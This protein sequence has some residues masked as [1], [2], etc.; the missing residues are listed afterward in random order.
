[1]NAI[2]GYN[3]LLAK[4][5]LS[6]KQKDFVEHGR[7]SATHLLGIINDILDFSKA[8]AGKLHV[9]NIEFDLNDLV[10]NLSTDISLKADEKGLELVIGVMEDV[11]RYLMGDPLRISEILSGL[12]NNAVKF[13]DV[14]HIVFDCSVQKLNNHNVTLKFS[15]TDTGCGLTEEDQNSLFGSFT[16]ADTSMT[17]KYDGL[18]LGLSNCKQLVKLMGGEIGCSGEPGSGSTFWFTCTFEYK[19]EL[20]M[21]VD[22]SEDIDHD[23]EFPILNE[24][25]IL[26]VE[27]NKINQL[28]MKDI[29]EDSGVSVTIA[30]NG[31][32][33][34]TLFQSCNF[35]AILMDVQMPVL[36]GYDATRQIR[37]IESK[38]HSDFTGVNTGENGGNRNT[39]I[40]GMTACS[41]TE[42]FDDAR[43]AGMNDCVSKPLDTRDLFLSLEKWFFLAENQNLN[44][45]LKTGEDLMDSLCDDRPVLN[46]S[47]ALSRVRGNRNLY[48]KLL[49]SFEMSNKNL[50]TELYE[51]NGNR[52]YEAVRVAIHKLNGAAGNLGAEALHD[53][54]GRIELAVKNGGEVK[55]DKLLQKF[56]YEYGRITRSIHDL[57]GETTKKGPQIQP[58]VE[59][60][61]SAQ[62]QELY[63][64]LKT[65]HSRA[66]RIIDD[67]T[68]HLSDS[69]VRHEFNQVQEAMDNFDTDRTTQKVKQIAQKLTIEL[70][71][72]EHE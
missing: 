57:T 45:K 59:E 71:E 31:Q 52:D 22:G 18:G 65:D 26:L 15:V 61:V 48:F 63:I 47:K 46:T 49:K 17:R 42:D 39:V 23:L 19:D 41:T 6:A 62:L 12:L 55:L 25:S 37:A 14:G 64:S 7:S 60:R 11:P 38:L 8:E 24:K 33:A 28:M 29:L 13:T 16:Q 36:G 30:V 35:D 20:M 43:K 10:C 34:V 70:Q 3:H 69:E 54:A 66:I 68:P 4:T 27:D 50:I 72:V 53:A 67:L 51:L 9:E 5:I 56:E 40:I 32:E 21:T 44:S 1:M 2:I 58:A